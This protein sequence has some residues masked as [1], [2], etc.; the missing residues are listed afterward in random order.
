MKVP[1]K[2]QLFGNEIKTVYEQ[3]LLDEQGL[4]GQTNIS[5]NEIRLKKI[6]EGRAFDNEGLYENYIHELL[7]I[8]IHKLG[9]EELTKDET[10]IEGFTN[11]LI[12]IIKQLK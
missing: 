1:D 10:F 8:M 6:Q 5:F 12:Q 11:L 9:Y 3:R 2:I 7:H 4:V